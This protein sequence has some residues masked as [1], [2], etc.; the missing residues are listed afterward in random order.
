M[1]HLLPPTSIYIQQ[2]QVS[3]SEEAISNKEESKITKD[4]IRQS[5]DDFEIFSNSRNLAKYEIIKILELIPKDLRDNPLE[6]GFY[7]DAG[8]TEDFIKSNKKED[9][10]RELNDNYI[11]NAKNSIIAEFYT[12]AKENGS[13]TELVKAVEDLL[14]KAPTQYT[15]AA[16][17]S[18]LKDVDI[19]KPKVGKYDGDTDFEVR[20][21]EQL[22][23]DDVLKRDKPIKLYPEQI[24]PI[25]SQYSEKE[26]NWVADR[27]IVIN[28][29]YGSIEIKKGDKLFIRV[30]DPANGD[31][32]SSTSY[33]VYIKGRSYPL[34][35]FIPETAEH[36]SLD[37]P[38][39]FDAVT[40]MKN[41]DKVLSGE[42]ETP[43]QSKEQRIKIAETL[44]PNKDFYVAKPYNSK[45]GFESPQKVIFKDGKWL[46]LRD[47]EWDNTKDY[48]YNVWGE[49]AD[50]NELAWDIV[51]NARVILKNKNADNLQEQWDKQFDYLT[52]EN[53]KRVSNEA[54]TQYTE[55][56]TPKPTVSSEVEGSGGVGGDVKGSEKEQKRKE[57][58]EAKEYEFTD[59]ETGT[60]S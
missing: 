42:I 19:T 56:A 60:K 13:N 31:A 25:D 11:N 40:Q 34:S 28:E 6:N 14:T 39:H 15:E 33:K 37:E 45:S 5:L 57:F 43:Q 50:K 2:V 8:I 18:A 4:S 54:P 32:T 3:P 9:F 36:G 21:P 48:E 30:D 59:S 1:K 22:N 29:G 47:D 44:I 12:R 35:H 41:F 51:S 38:N 23:I 7:K 52:A 16:G 46:R 58:A 27:D 10:F 53:K 20:T 17:G 49:Y 55:A 26:S 24:V